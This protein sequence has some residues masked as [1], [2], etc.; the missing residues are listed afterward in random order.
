MLFLSSLKWVNVATLS[1]EK[2]EMY[3]GGLVRNVLYLKPLLYFSDFK[4]FDLEV[5]WGNRL[6]RSNGITGSI[7]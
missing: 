1:M 2:K 3:Q 5:F 7:S 6:L 4:P